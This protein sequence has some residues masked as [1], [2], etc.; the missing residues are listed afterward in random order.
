[1]QPGSYIVQLDASGHLARFSDVPQRIDREPKRISNGQIWHG[2]FPMRS[3]GA[4]SPLA[5]DVK[6]RPAICSGNVF[7][8]RLA[9]RRDCIVIWNIRNCWNMEADIT[10]KLSVITKP[11]HNSFSGS[12]P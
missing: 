7:N 12:R 2:S 8:W 6:M 9:G 1:M 3:S 10:N 11:D 5:M 4:Y